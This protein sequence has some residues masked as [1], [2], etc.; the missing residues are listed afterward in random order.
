M[1][2]PAYH[3]SRPPFDSVTKVEHP[4]N[5]RLLMTRVVTLIAIIT[6]TF[7]TSAQCAGWQ[8][9]AEARMACCANETECPMHPAGPG[10]AQSPRSVTQSQAD[11]CCSLSEHSSSTP[12]ASSHDSLYTLIAQS[13]LS[14]VP[15]LD[16]APV[17]HTWHAVTAISAVPVPRHL[18]LS[19]FLI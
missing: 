1:K 10:G 5:V 13:T 18:L 3:F 17:N 2:Y 19:V 6:L 12:S 15:L 7:N 16:T 4:R 8:E 9:T 11:A 14:T